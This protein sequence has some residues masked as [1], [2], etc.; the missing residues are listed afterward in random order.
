MGVKEGV[1]DANKDGEMEGSK[2]GINVGVEEGRGIGST[3][4]AEVGVL[5]GTAE[6]KAVGSPVGSTVG[7]NVGE[8]VGA[9]VGKEDGVSEGAKLGCAVEGPEVGRTDVDGAEDGS[10]V[11]A[12]EVGVKVGGGMG[13]RGPMFRG[14]MPSWA[15]ATANKRRSCLMVGVGSLFRKNCQ[16]AEAR[17]VVGCAPAEIQNR[18]WPLRST[19]KTAG[20][21]DYSAEAGPSRVTHSL[22]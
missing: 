17:K 2:I 7:G 9:L 22:S 13:G 11:G 4:G 14:T 21:D 16:H 19:L 10:T 18:K 20:R 5:V 15:D 12:N 6:G 1:K 8:I 3:V